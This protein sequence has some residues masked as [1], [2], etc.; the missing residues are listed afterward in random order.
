MSE[1]AGMLSDFFRQIKDGTIGIE[2]MRAIVGHPYASVIVDWQ[3]FYRDIGIKTDFSNLR[4]P[5]KLQGFDRLI[6]VAQGMTPQ[7]L[8]DKCKELFSCWKWTDEN[9]DKIVTSD[10]SAKDSAYAAWF[11]DRVEADDE[12]K[13]LSANALKEKS[14]A[15]VTLEERLVY[16]LKYFKET[17]KH[18]DIENVTLCT[19]SRYSDGGV[20]FVDW[21]AGDRLRVRWYDPDDT[22]GSLRVRQAVS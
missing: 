14:V 2:R 1:W 15:G 12:L 18:L 17:G 6:V 20:P 21:R 8:Y 5:E 11:R 4:I 13:S 19:G 7:R 22:D 10:R 3:N 9:L 16:E